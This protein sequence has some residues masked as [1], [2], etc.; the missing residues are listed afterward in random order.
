MSGSRKQAL[1]AQQ[2]RV[3]HVNAASPDVV[4]AAFRSAHART[5]AS[6]LDSSIP[7]HSDTEKFLKHIDQAQRS[8]AVDAIAEFSSVGAFL[9]CIDAWSLLGRSIDA[10]SVG[11]VAEA[12]HLAYYSEVRSTI[13]MMARSGLL[14]VG[15]QTVAINGKTI[16]TVYN[17]ASTHES[18]WEALRLWSGTNAAVET[19]AR[20]INFRGIP[21]SRWLDSAR[22]GA[23]AATFSAFLTEAWG[24]DLEEMKGD[25]S[26]RNIA[27]YHPSGLRRAEPENYASWF[28]EVVVG[29]VG[30]LSP[31]TPGTFPDLDAVIATEVLRNLVGKSDP[32]GDVKRIVSSA[33]G[34][35]Y[36]AEPIIEELVTSVGSA[37]NSCIADA[38][39]R[40]STP[41]RQFTRD[42]VRSMLGR[43]VLL[44]R[45]C[46]AA[47]RDMQKRAGLDQ[48]DFRWWSDEVGIMSGFWNPT[49][50][51][52]PLT[53]LW[54][55]LESALDELQS[56]QFGGSNGSLR[57]RHDSHWMAREIG[58]VS[59]A[60]L[61]SLSA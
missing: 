48:V 35:P 52:D 46:T 10:L 23:A 34:S 26:R 45:F 31:G 13:S 18:A 56:Q 27:S 6:W 3:S 50:K 47:V 61:W 32:E 33:F 42:D 51:P 40:S 15:T 9:H 12:A 11:S 58:G 2:A 57:I 8:Q 16:E 22:P 60:A 36:G 1:Q 5:P 59:R 55:D 44:A 25:R 4:A 39:R 19:V 54:L 21:L 38:M 41:I 7:E 14:I 43:A 20:S 49:P 28:R 24:S 30:V 29:L 17:G 37:G 53:D